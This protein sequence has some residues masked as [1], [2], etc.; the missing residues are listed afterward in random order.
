[1]IFSELGNLDPLQGLIAAAIVFV[2]GFIRG[3]VGFGSALIIV[4]VLALMFTPQ[5]AVIM[6]GIMDL[7]SNFQLLPTA[8]RHCSRRTVVPMAL[9]LAAGI[10]IGVYFLSSVDAAPMRII[11]SIL[12]LV[13]VGLLALNTRIV[14]GTGVKT[15]VS[16]GIIGGIIHGMSAVGG[17]PVVA[18]LTARKDA[19]VTT[20][21]NVVVIMSLLVLSGILGYWAFGLITVQSLVLGG[22]AAPIYMLAT[23]LGSRYFRTG[24][25]G[26][27]RTM[28]LLVLA[29]TSISTLFLSFW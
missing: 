20:R 8:V 4:P 28:T 17:P 12:V 14:F 10:P 26:I 19:P 25:S 5:L 3:F 1:M 23:Y 7:P 29:L 21:G 16:S 24:G 13:M 22:F 11:I 15:L 18:F 2:G 6:H 27:Y 9:S